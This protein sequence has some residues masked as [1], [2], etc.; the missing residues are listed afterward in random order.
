MHGPLITFPIENQVVF[1][2]LVLS[3]LLFAPMLARLLKVPDIIVLILAG[4]LLGPNGVG[5]LERGSRVVLFGTIG[6][7]YIMF[8]AGLEMDLNDF[9]KNRNRSLIFGAATFF[10]PMIIGTAASY[11]VLQYSLVSSILLASMLASHTLLA[12]PA[13]SRLGINRTQAV[14]VAVGGTMITDTAALLVLA[15]IAQTASGVLDASFWFQMVA[16]LSLF[17]FVVLVIM[18]KIGR[19]YFRTFDDQVSH[20]IFVMTMIFMASTLAEVAGVEAIIGAFLGGLALNRLIPHSS[21]LMNR[22]EFIGNA[23]F[24][25][26]FLLSVGMLV[27]FSV[28][29]KSA[30]A[31]KA[32]IVMLLIALV[33]KYLA[34]HVSQ[35]LFG[36]SKNER[37]VMFGLS[38]A[39][40][41]ATLATVMVGFDLGLLDEDVLN[42]S[43]IVILVTCMIASFSMEHWGRALAA[44]QNELPG[45]EVESEERV[46]V[47][48]ANP[49]TMEG[50]IDLAVLTRA[51]TSFTPIFALAVVNDDTEVRGSL[52]KSRKRLEKAVNYANSSEHA[53]Q[54]ITRVDVHV[55][56]GVI[57]AAKDL[58]VSETI[59]GWN[60]KLT[61]QQKL[62]GSVL[63]SLLS[64][65]SELLVVSHLE[66][67]LN[68]LSNVR[69]ILSQGICNDP[70]LAHG[71]ALIKRLLKQIGT[72]LTVELCPNEVTTFQEMY[73]GVLPELPC[74][75]EEHP[76]WLERLQVPV[77]QNELL[78]LV[79]ARTGTIAYSRAQTR[80]PRLLSD[81][82]GDKNF[83]VLYPGS[84]ESQ[85]L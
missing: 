16:K 24:I 85:P 35:V 64:R 26:F 71:L 34:A 68:S 67:S 28:F 66:Q 4:A 49:E 80:V 51:P 33:S 30:S 50:L 81:L 45:A 19:W 63:D 39:Q 57:R 69:M 25:P 83:L 18:P 6:L 72:P 58:G 37:M 3:V 20:Y 8:V 41:A 84:A 22:V 82:H 31:L 47:P 76:D 79:G 70:G 75:I 10:I 65:G 38:N 61:T 29:F 73:Q 62:F 7:L 59:I 48:I 5:L 32:A 60:A 77:G 15:V 27:D 43:I 44:E 23:I 12:Y 11:W 52:A 54:I 42:G 36:Y 1:F 53:L 40:A 74:K 78:I 46:L 13:A 14:N 21:P 9:K 2:T 56:R 17:S 55:A